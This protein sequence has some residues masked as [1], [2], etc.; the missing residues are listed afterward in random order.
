MLK[1][2]TCDSFAIASVTSKAMVSLARRACCRHGRFRRTV[3]R[4]DWLRRRRGL[5]HI[6]PFQHQE[7]VIGAACDR[8]PPRRAA[9][10]ACAAP[11]AFR[12]SRPWP[13]AA[14]GA[15]AAPGASTT[16]VSRAES[17]DRGAAR[18]RA[19]D[20]RS[21]GAG[22]RPRARGHRQALRRARG[23]VV[24]AVAELEL[25]IE[26]V[27]AGHDA[28]V[29]VRVEKVSGVVIQTSSSTGACAAARSVHFTHMPVDIGARAARTSDRAPRSPAMPRSPSRPITTMNAVVQRASIAPARRATAVGVGDARQPPKPPA[30]VERIG[31]REAR[32]AQAPP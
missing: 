12:P 19:T 10:S 24:V 3:Q 1:P 17:I 27:G 22:A 20:Q 29:A 23:I 2:R 11:P 14:A 15:A 9:R 5:E 6:R 31:G 32:R 16:A 7:Q 4:A 13:F 26:H 28:V 30:R 8:A 21:G 25:G 18:R